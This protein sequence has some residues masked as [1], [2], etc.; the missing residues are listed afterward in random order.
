MLMNQYVCLVR[1]PYMRLTDDCVGIGGKGSLLMEKYPGPL[2]NTSV[3]K[4]FNPLNE[5]LFY[6]WAKTADGTEDKAIHSGDFVRYGDTHISTVHSPEATCDDKGKNCTYE[7]IHASGNLCLDISGNK[8]CEADEPFNRKV[9][10]NSTQHF[11]TKP[12]GFG[13]IKLWD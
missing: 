3:M 1:P 12:T 2:M 6:Y 4:I 10:T 7:I 9:V 8:K 13:R 11:R 5:D